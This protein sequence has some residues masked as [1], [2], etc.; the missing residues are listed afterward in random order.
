MR[1]VT[2]ADE[3][4][5]IWSQ[6]LD[7]VAKVV[8]PDWGSLIGLLPLF[9]FLGVI[10]PLLTLLGLLWFY[11]FV[12]K[13]RTRVRFLEG[14]R[15]AQIAADGLPL[16]PVGEPFDP[17]S[18][19]DLS[20]RHGRERGR[21][22]ALGDLPDVRDCPP[23]CRDHLHQLRSRPQ[24]RPAGRRP[25]LAAGRTAARWSCRRLSPVAGI[26]VIGRSQEWERG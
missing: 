24:G 17:Q 16:F 22:P 4:S 12:T 9:L 20:G 8:S 13:P 5:Q 11:Y 18:R 3:I 7:V 2:L 25:D 23:G 10:A 19:P 21:R 14:P 1:P 26:V 15:L 6:I